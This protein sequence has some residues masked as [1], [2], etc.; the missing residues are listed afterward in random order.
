MVQEILFRFEAPQLSGKVL[1]SEAVRQTIA[2]RKYQPSLTS[3]SNV[4]HDLH[5]F[6]QSFLFN[7]YLQMSRVEIYCS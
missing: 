3:Q 5:S 6:K 2:I 1:D 4:V 7:Y